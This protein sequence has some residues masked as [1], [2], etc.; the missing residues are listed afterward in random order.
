MIDRA[1]DH[2]IKHTILSFFRKS[3]DK[4]GGD[5][6]DCSAW[7]TMMT[8]QSLSIVVLSTGVDNLNEIRAALAMD[9]R[10]KL[11]SAGND[12]EKIQEEIIRLQPSAAIISLGTE[13]ERAIRLIRYIKSNC[14]KTAIIT[15]AGETSADLILQSLRAGSDEFLRL[16]INPDELRTVLDQIGELSMKI[17]EATTE[18]G[19]MTAIFSNKGGCGASFIAANLAATATDRAV[20]VDLN[21][22]SGD[23]P[24]FFGLNPE[25]SISD[26]VARHGELDG[27]LISTLVTPCGTNLDMICAPKELD[28]IE[29]IEPE[30][31]FEL[32]QRLRENY[33][34]ILLDLR[35]TFDAITLMA[36]EQCDE[37][38]LVL[39]LDILAIRSAHRA[40]KFFERE[41]YSASKVK[42]LV[43]R[44]SK[45][46]DWNLPEVEKFLHKKV[47]GTLSSHYPTVVESINV[48]KPL[49]KSNPRSEIAEELKRFAHAL[50]IGKSE[51]EEPARYWKHFWRGQTAGCSESP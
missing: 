38:V 11:L 13:P 39:S 2:P 23:L 50:S 14:S 5:N 46:I 47:L 45:Q 16:P 42:I 44:W 41:G 24:L 30:Y 18:T 32:L 29:K 4:E 31:I 20:L 48:G 9:S 37:I 7:G 22:E 25:Y 17:R 6:W 8:T 3:D 27:S 35:H 51:R 43:N 26:I 12:V 34:H 1:P 15:V 21:F 40:L 49:V 10:A 33:D 19:R 36:L 28:P